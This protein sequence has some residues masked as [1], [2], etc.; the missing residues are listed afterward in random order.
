MNSEIALNILGQVLLA[1][2]DNTPLGVNEYK[3]FQAF[4]KS[5]QYFHLAWL[6]EEIMGVYGKRDKRRMLNV[7]EYLLA[8]RKLSR[9]DKKMYEL[10]WPASRRAYRE[11]VIHT[12]PEIHIKVDGTKR[13]AHV[14]ITDDSNHII[15]YDS[16]NGAL[17]PSEIIK[18][19]SDIDSR[20]K[21]RTKDII[22]SGLKDLVP[23]SLK[24]YFL[25]GKFT[26]DMGNS[27]HDDNSFS[28]GHEIRLKATS[29]H[30]MAYAY[31]PDYFWNEDAMRRTFENVVYS[32]WTLA[33]ISA[34]LPKDVEFICQ[35]RDDCGVS[36]T[37][38]PPS[39][40]DEEY[41]RR[42][43]V[44]MVY[45]DLQ[46]KSPLDEEDYKDIMTYCNLSNKLTLQDFTRMCMNDINRLQDRKQTICRQLGGQV[47]DVTIV[48]N[49]NSVNIF[50]KKNR[51]NKWERECFIRA[52]YDTNQSFLKD[53][54]FYLEKSKELERV[55][56]KSWDIETTVGLLKAIDK[57]YS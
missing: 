30:D 26:K 53:I 33:E 40:G 27:I 48:F 8:I 5:V 46:Y 19:F 36:F 17:Y 56:E 16:S 51:E 4:H 44:L 43:A 11:L 29:T 47:D 54:G 1:G 21:D 9:K 7:N 6:K 42:R 14:Q 15:V 50:L 22:I 3:D 20:L 34:R 18:L 57:P 55:F 23:D 45:K 2:R 32:Y 25:R 28:I 31:I 37:N 49:V 39:I 10:W 41:L 38:E 24:G 35:H 52:S 13:K 12:V